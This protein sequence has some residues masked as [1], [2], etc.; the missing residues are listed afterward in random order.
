[1]GV[2]FKEKC[3]NL[4]VSKS[5]EKVRIKLEWL[6]FEQNWLRKLKDKKVHMFLDGWMD[7]SKSRFKDSLQQ[8]KI[9]VSAQNPNLSG[10]RTLGDC[11]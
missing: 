5:W 3:Q 9:S 7:I 4:V 6:S 2:N 11:L 1:M 10:N 8:S